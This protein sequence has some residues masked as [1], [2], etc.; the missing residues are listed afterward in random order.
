MM[1]QRSWRGLKL[2]SVALAAPNDFHQA[3]LVELIVQIRNYLRGKPCR[4]RPV[5]YDVRLFYSEDG[6]DDT[7]VQPDISVICDEKKWGPEGCRGAP[8]LAVEILSP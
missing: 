2:I 4:V 8:D 3:M 5:P 1:R 6:N 7:V